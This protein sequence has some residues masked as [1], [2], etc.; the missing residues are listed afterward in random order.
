MPFDTINCLKF[1]DPLK[2]SMIHG[3][4]VHRQ[5]RQRIA[6]LRHGVA[7][8]VGMPTWLEFSAARGRIYSRR[9]GGSV[10]RSGRDRRFSHRLGKGDFY[11]SAF[12]IQ[13]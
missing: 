3:G 13:C 8:A 5:T 9:G 4:R 7:A 12:R 1:I 10:F 6:R 11:V 2:E